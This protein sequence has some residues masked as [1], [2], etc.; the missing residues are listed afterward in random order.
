MWIGGAVGV[1]RPCFIDEW[2]EGKYHE[3]RI[4]LYNSR[5]QAAEKRQYNITSVGL[6]QYEVRR[7][8]GVA[9]RVTICRRFGIPFAGCDCYDFSTYGGGFNRACQHIWVVM[10]T[11]DIEVC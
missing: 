2:D 5:K 9:H 6:N 1:M 4:L 7:P 10:L 8:G 11:Q 3:D